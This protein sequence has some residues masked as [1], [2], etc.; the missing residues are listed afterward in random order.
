MVG[1]SS[2]NRAETSSETISSDPA[3]N[4]LAEVALAIF[5]A[6]EQVL[7]RRVAQTRILTATPHVE[8][9]RRVSLQY[10]SR[11]VVEIFAR[12]GESVKGE[13]LLPLGIFRKSLFFGFDVSDASGAPVPLVSSDLDSEIAAAMCI[14]C[15]TSKFAP[16]V[17]IK[18]ALFETAR[19][20]SHETF[21]EVLSSRTGD[22]ENLTDDELGWLED[23]LAVRDF[24]RLS[25]LLSAYYLP[26]ARIRVDSAETLLK[27]QWIEAMP[28][29]DRGDD[30]DRTEFASGRSDAYVDA[31]D[32]LRITRRQLDKSYLI[33]FFEIPDF[34]WARSEHVR[35]AAPA[36]TFISDQKL[37]LESSSPEGFPE[38]VVP[39][40]EHSE[41]SGRSTFYVSHR[42]L[43]PKPREGVRSSRG[44]KSWRRAGK[45]RDKTDGFLAGRPALISFFVRPSVRHVLLPSMVL[46][47]S[48]FAL[49]ATFAMAEFGSQW[50]SCNG[51]SPMLSLSIVDSCI[52]KGYL[53]QAAGSADA[54][55]TIL[56]LAST[57]TVAYIVRPAE[58]DVVRTRLL[59]PWRARALLCL[60]PSGI[61][62][63]V[64]L[65]PRGLSD[66]WF[67]WA[68]WCALSVSSLLLALNVTSFWA[69]VRRAESL[70]GKSDGSTIRRE[71]GPPRD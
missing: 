46:V 8:L 56:L 59:R 50:F 19:R 53:W 52:E 31:I 2:W 43:V 65:S 54:I 51:L 12:H 18:A 70:S 47:W 69:S 28:A 60:V 9:E 30:R 7:A 13:I 22:L 55:V 14:A 27:V 40:H 10:D 67:Y 1:A 41:S 24:A 62:A 36:E 35:I 4:V 6:Q 23:A 11:R 44:S 42:D 64:F 61:A 3:S 34:G 33:A 63:L 45:G 20:N 38:L 17:R 48:T 26:F 5:S 16:S 25:T 21:W 32:G 29:L 71:P 57:L 68:S 39:P 37:T 58:E 66:P 49:L 15:V